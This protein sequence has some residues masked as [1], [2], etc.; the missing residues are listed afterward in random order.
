MSMHGHNFYGTRQWHHLRDRYAKEQDF[1]CER[2]YRACYTRDD[3]RYRRMKR[4]GQ[5]V[6]FGIVHHK[7]HLTTKTVHDPKIA[8]EWD[9][10]E[11]L[12][13]S[14]HNK[15]HSKAKQPIEVREDVKFDDRGYIIYE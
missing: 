13:I 14:C 8:L 3:E 5:D 6:V 11:F 9:N 12:C 15:E 4:Q 2:C 7:E 10:L 1:I